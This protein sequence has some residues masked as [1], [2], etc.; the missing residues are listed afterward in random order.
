[1]YVNEYLDFNDINWNQMLMN[2]RLQDLD[3]KHG[4][5]DEG[6]PLL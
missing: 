6:K 5:I 3:L 4:R 2:S 1:M